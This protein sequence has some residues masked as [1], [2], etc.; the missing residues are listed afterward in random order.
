MDILEHN[1]AVIIQRNYRKHLNRIRKHQL[2]LNK[3]NKDILN[4]NTIDRYVGNLQNNM[5]L[6]YLLSI[7]RKRAV[8]SV[9]KSEKLRAENKKVYEE[10][11]QFYKN[12]SANRSRRTYLETILND[13]DKNLS[14]LRNITSLDECQMLNFTTNTENLQREDMES[15]SNQEK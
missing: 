14:L 3:N 5:P 4:E 1:S 9:D 6:N 13:I 7:C 10:L 2:K 15:K 11:R 8:L 12:L